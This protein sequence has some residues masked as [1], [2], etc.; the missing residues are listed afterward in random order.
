[1]TRDREK[2]RYFRLSLELICD[3]LTLMQQYELTLIFNAELTEEKAD[4]IIDSFKLDVL[5]RQV[6]G[7][8]HLAYPIDNKKEGLYI[9]LVV[10]LKPESITAIE[11]AIQLHDEVIRHLLVKAEKEI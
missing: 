8:R 11:R 6:W 7:K 1:L 5:H 4:A 3:I 9:M 2:N 10:K